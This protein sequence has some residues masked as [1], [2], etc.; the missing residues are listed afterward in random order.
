MILAHGDHYLYRRLLMEE[1][2]VGRSAANV[3]YTRGTQLQYGNQLAN[4]CFIPV[5]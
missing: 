5:H 2:Q 1:E 4:S 3:C